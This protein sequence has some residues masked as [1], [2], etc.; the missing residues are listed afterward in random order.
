MYRRE[1]TSLQTGEVCTA[2]SP[3]YSVQND[4][5]VSREINSLDS[6]CL[7]WGCEEGSV[8]RGEEGEREGLRRN[9]TGEDPCSLRDRRVS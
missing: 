8:R 4:P 1:F 5:L 2:T 6:C 9:F 7:L 3:Q